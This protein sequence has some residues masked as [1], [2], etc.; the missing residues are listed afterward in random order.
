M[1][2]TI[3]GLNCKVEVALTFDS[4]VSPTGVTK[5][6]PAVVSLTSHGLAA[7][8]VGYWTATSGMVQLHKQAFVV[9]NPASGT[10]D[11]SGL[12]TTDY[13]T[14]ASGPTVTTA[15]TWGTLV[16][17]SGYSVGGGASTE[18]DDTRLVDVKTRSEAGLL[19]SQSL[20]I[21]IRN[22]RLGSAAM[23]YV[24][25]MAARGQ[26]ILVKITQAGQIVR[27]AYG[28]PSLPGEGVASGQLASGQMSIIVPAFALKPDSVI[29]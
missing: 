5:A 9:D 1:T 2:D 16:E 22:A 19:Q 23:I 15:A 7:G 18:L 25:R 10:W 28:V 8:T 14:F 12:D 27:V 4:P 21:D 26:N 20:T 29:A 11:M 24:Q 6:F 3:K 17:A 13:D